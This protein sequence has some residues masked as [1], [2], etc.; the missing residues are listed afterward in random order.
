MSI[1]T[2]ISSPLHRQVKTISRSGDIYVG[3]GGLIEFIV[4]GIHL[5]MQ[6]IADHEG[7]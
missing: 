6:F 2:L 3:S 4:R 1:A 7:G 5:K